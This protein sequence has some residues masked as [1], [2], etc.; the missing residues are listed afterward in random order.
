MMMMANFFEMMDPED[1]SDLDIESA[2]GITVTPR[3]HALQDLSSAPTMRGSH[4]VSNMTLIPDSFLTPSPEEQIIRQ[5][6]RLFN[7]TQSTPSLKKEDERQATPAK[8]NSLSSLS[9]KRLL[10]S[11]E[12]SPVKTPGKR[13][14]LLRKGSEVPLSQELGGY[15]QKQLVGVIDRLVAMHPHLEDEVRL[16]LPSPDIKPLEDNLSFL[17]KNI[18]RAFPTTRWSSSRD[19]H[20]YKRVKVHL[21]T[22]KKACLEQGK[23]LLSAG[24]WEAVIRYT[25]MAW[26]YTGRLPDWDDPS[27]NTHKQQCYS[28]L[29]GQCMA[30]LKKGGFEKEQLLQYKK[31][32]EAACSLNAELRPCVAYIEKTLDTLQ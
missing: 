1:L 15:S 11:P 24:C 25:A 3:R 6:S 7:R 20:C 2:L 18:F 23:A 17:R 5:R 9:R 22:F 31:K 29:A 27:H 28:V 14:R 26:R 12:A 13:A 10:L 8:E 19:V 4:S 21:L 30:A 32:L 16:R